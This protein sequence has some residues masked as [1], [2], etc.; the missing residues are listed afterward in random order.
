MQVTIGEGFVV[1]LAIGTESRPFEAV[2]GSPDGTE[3]G[4]GAS[5]FVVVGGSTGTIGTDAGTR[6]FD[7]G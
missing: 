5:I 3:I 2:E 7:P 1:R 6:T 4:G